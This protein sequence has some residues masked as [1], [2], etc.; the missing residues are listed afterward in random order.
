MRILFLSLLFGFVFSFLFFGLN[1]P[2][3]AANEH[4]KCFQI[5]YADAEEDVALKYTQSM[6]ELYKSIGI[7][8]EFI[9]L[10]YNRLMYMVQNNEID[11]VMGRTL[12]A[13]M[14]FSNLP[15]VPTPVLNIKGFLVTTPDISARIKDNHDVIKSYN[16]GGMYSSDWSTHTLEK[17][18]LD[19]EYAHQL[20]QLIYMYE[21]GRIDGFLLSGKYL[22]LG[23]KS[24]IKTGKKFQNT[25]LYDVPVYHILAPK[26]EKLI[27]KLDQVIRI[28]I[29]QRKFALN[30]IA[31]HK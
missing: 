5:G 30:Q 24:L 18:N 23:M 11:A 4:E 12:P 8:A 17:M 6:G 3:H 28:M 21:K 22:E 10:P 29:S 1:Q 26:N 16:F 7:C 27:D 20:D 25:L 14:E 2:V 31:M 19:V 15:Y 9:K 13:I